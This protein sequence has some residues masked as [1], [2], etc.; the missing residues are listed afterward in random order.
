MEF[1]I[2]DALVDWHLMLEMPHADFSF[3][4]QA[5][6]NFTRLCMPGVPI[7]PHIYRVRSQKSCKPHLA[8][9]I[10]MPQTSPGAE[11][12]RTLVRA[13]ARTAPT[14][15]RNPK[16]PQKES[17]HPG[18]VQGTEGLEELSGTSLVFF[19]QKVP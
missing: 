10:A 17:R 5:P 12:Q 14:A 3:S 11:E 9:D 2:K 7:R 15:N 18:T 19:L 4:R 16:N 6:R 1:I 13:Q 8:L